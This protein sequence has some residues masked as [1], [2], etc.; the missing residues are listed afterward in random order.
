[1]H[2][3]HHRISL[4]PYTTLFRSEGVWDLYVVQRFG[5]DEL[6]NRLGRNRSEDVTDER[7]LLIA[8]D[9]RREVGVAYFT[10]VYGNLS[11]DIGYTLLA[12]TRPPPPVAR[13]LDT[14]P[15]GPAA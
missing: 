13:A 2:L 9:R 12:R 5:A 14:G 7:R 3:C 6:E 1:M 11:L 15:G 10:K 4:L 8:S